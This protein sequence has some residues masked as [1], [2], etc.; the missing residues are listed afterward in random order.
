MD[1][2][3]KLLHLFCS[4]HGYRSKRNYLDIS[5]F[6]LQPVNDYKYSKFDKMRPIQSKKV[7]IMSYCLFI[8]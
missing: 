4:E 3:K 7:R 2:V 8:R 1:T 6:T 5:M